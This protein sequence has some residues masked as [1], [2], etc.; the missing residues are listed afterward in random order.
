MALDILNIAETAAVVVH[1]VATFLRV[2][3]PNLLGEVLHR[4]LIQNGVVHYL[5]TVVFHHLFE[6]EGCGLLDL[7]QRA[8][9]WV[10]RHLRLFVQHRWL[11]HC[12][13]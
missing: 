11:R 5:V 2:R 6:F 9:H 8:S 3:A 13:R 7:A 1:K 12:H 4:L 10:D